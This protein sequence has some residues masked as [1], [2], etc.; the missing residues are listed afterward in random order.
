MLDKTLG[1]PVSTVS[2]GFR[3]R[4]RKLCR[5]SARI[6]SFGLQCFVSDRVAVEVSVPLLV[7]LALFIVGYESSC[8]RPARAGAAQRWRACGASRWAGPVQ[9]TFVSEDGSRNIGRS[10]V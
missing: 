1:A 7:P 8:R 5:A 9:R 2:R 4:G 10:G 6:Q 3:A